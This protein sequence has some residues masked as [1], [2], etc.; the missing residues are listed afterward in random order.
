[1]HAS[2]RV[3]SRRKSKY[4]SAHDAPLNNQGAYDGEKCLL[5][6][7]NVVIVCLRTCART[8]FA[9]RLIIHIYDNEISQLCNIVRFLFPKRNINDWQEETWL[10]LVREEWN[11][12]NSTFIQFSHGRYALM[13]IGRCKYYWKLVT[14]RYWKVFH[15]CYNEKG[16]CTVHS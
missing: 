2:R 5:K 16:A 13:I 3:A 15:I 9:P 10:A 7:E 1:M 11:C 8:H 12:R 14:I 4:E 6:N